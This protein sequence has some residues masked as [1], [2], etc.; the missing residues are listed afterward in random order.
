[1][2]VPSHPPQLQVCPSLTLV[3]GSLT[4]HTKSLSSSDLEADL[5]AG[6]WMHR[7]GP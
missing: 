7:Q 3:L 4:P 6:T 1:M 5:L 2:Y